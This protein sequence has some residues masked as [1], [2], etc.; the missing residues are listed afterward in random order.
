MLYDLT[1]IKGRF[2]VYAYLTSKGA[3][4]G[5]DP[6]SLV[7]YSVLRVSR[8]QAGCFSFVDPRH[9]TDPSNSAG[10]QVRA[11]NE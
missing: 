8:A 1:D 2:V 9:L 5:P 6:T 7:S 4:R 10:R 3:F 11:L